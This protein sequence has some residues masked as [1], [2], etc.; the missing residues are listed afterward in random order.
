M[1]IQIYYD[2]LTQAATAFGCSRQWLSKLIAQGLL[3][4]YEVEG[5]PQARRVFH[6]DVAEALART[7][8][9][10]R[11]HNCVCY[12]VAHLQGIEEGRRE[13]APQLAEA[14]QELAKALEELAQVRQELSEVDEEL[15]EAAQVVEPD[16]EE[17]IAALLVPFSE[18]GWRVHAEIDMRLHRFHD[19]E[20][21][22]YHGFREAWFDALPPQRRN[23]LRFGNREP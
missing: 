18:A 13:S 5:Q 9:G 6:Q 23:W 3:V 14:R 1:T 20:T 19:P 16:Q 8:S 15:T 10:L 12:T 11:P 2:S 7:E 17:I 21:A 4:S 22:P